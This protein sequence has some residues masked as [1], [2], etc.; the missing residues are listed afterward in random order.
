MRAKF[1]M[2]LWFHADEA[3]LPEDTPEENGWERDETYGY[4]PLTTNDLIA[5]V[6]VVELV[7]CKS[8]KTGCN[9]KRCAC[10]RVGEAC[11]DF[12]G[13]GEYCENVDMPG[14]RFEVDCEAEA[15]EDVETKLTCQD[16]DFVLPLLCFCFILCVSK[17]VK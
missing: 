17:T 13:C 11:T 5:P 16:T 10:Y 6:S 1:Q 12:C 7:S 9:T 2:K 15:E 8:C 14:P 4:L 3:V